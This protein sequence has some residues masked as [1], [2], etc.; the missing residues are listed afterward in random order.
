[1]GLP[2]LEEYTPEEQEK[3]DRLKNKSFQSRLKRK[4]KYSPNLDWV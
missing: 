4:K 1:M 3:M 2:I